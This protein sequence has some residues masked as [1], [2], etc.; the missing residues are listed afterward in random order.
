[1]IKQGLTLLAALMSLPLYGQSASTVISEQLDIDYQ[2]VD[3]HLAQCPQAISKFHGLDSCYQSR[4]HLTLPVALSSTDWA[5]YFSHLMPVVESSSAQFNIT[6]I[7]GDLHKITPKKTFSGFDANQ[8]YVIDFI[9]GG[10]QITRSEFM[11]NFFVHSKGQQ[12]QI[13]DSTRIVIEPETGLELQP[14]LRPFVD[15][16]KQF[17]LASNDNTQW[18]DS[19]AIYQSQ[20]QFSDTI[21]VKHRLIP[22]PKSQQLLPKLAAADLSNGISLTTT[23][24]NDS[25][26]TAVLARLSDLGVPQSNQGLAVNI[27][28]SASNTL[29]DEGY[30]MRVTPEQITIRAH[31]EQGA[32]YA[33]QSLAGLVTTDDLTI[34]AMEIDDAPHYPFRGLHIDVARNFLSKAFILQTLEQMA[35]H[36]MNKLHLHLADDEGWRLAIDSLPELTEVGSR[37]C[38][39]E[40]PKNCLLPQLG[41]DIET[42]K[43]QFY[44]QQDYLDILAYAKARHIQ[45]IP[46][47]D[48]PGHSRAAIHAMESR[49][50]RLLAKGEQQAATKYRLIEPEDTTHYYS[51]QHYTDN[52]LN[53]CIDATYRFIDTVISDVQTMHKQAGMPLYIYHIGADETAGAWVDSPSCQQL[54]KRLGDQLAGLN[55]LNGYFIERISSMLNKKGIQVAGWNDGMGETRTQNMPSKVQTNSWSQ[56]YHKGHV[57]THQ[58]ANRGWQTVIST[59]D[60]T[61]FDFPYQAHPQEPGN[62]WAARHISTE[63]VFQFMPDNLPAHA[64]I[65]RDTKEQPYQSDDRQS[66]LKKGNEF[67]GIQGH[68]WTEMIRT[69][70]RAQYMLYPRLFA[71]AERAWHLPKWALPY[72]YEGKQYNQATNHFDKAAQHQRDQQWFA[73]ATTLSLKVLPKLERKGIEYRIPTV[74]TQID[75]KQLKTSTSL[76]ALPIEYQDK[77]GNWHQQQPSVEQIH[78]V[79]ATS[80]DGQRKGRSLALQPK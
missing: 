6:H 30:Q 41:S 29:A 3:S 21:D 17:K 36:K 8:T 67:K 57:A 58:Q 73:F 5:I 42:T 12:A 22:T 48:M 11:P 79:R 63:K 78:A 13:I 24:I 18:A 52:T 69:D 37:R 31:D 10:S 9:S 65:W 38:F 7:N 53:V 59:P 61:Y 70:E 72:D 46:S 64:E 40:T 43:K 49:Y 75:G 66:Q 39:E 2:L 71:L 80:H 47:L 35:A 56:L 76:P 54:K 50:Q 74:G 77:Q 26:L 27:E 45:V 33:L 44:S 34:P 20:P 14:Y 62:H 51:I 68:L 55:T 60:V 4:L 25:Q 23:G 15:R 28:I 16:N 19:Q 1:M 32:F